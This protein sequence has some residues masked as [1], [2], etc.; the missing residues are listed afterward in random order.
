[1]PQ[2]PVLA[3]LV[4]AALPA[5]LISACATDPE[6]K[7]ENLTVTSMGLPAAFHPGDTSGLW[8]ANRT[9]LSATGRELTD[10]N[11]APFHLESSDT[12]I[13]AVVKERFVTARKP[14]TAQVTA[15][16]DKSALKSEAAAVTVVGP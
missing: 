12:S 2:R 5:I 7:S 13:V 14:G 16:D 3:Y 6:K 1:M 15:Y 8:T 10:K 11:Y 4:S 9:T